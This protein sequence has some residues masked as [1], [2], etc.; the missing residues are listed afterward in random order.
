MHNPVPVYWIMQSK[1][2][3]RKGLSGNDSPVEKLD[4]SSHPAHHAVI[5]PAGCG[6]D[7]V[8][9][10]RYKKTIPSGF[11]EGA[12]KASDMGEGA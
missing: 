1:N 11:P 3:N 8:R 6:N 7:T 9:L 2:G 12:G 10:N 4:A 5:L